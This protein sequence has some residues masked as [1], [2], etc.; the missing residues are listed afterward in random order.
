MTIPEDHKEANPINERTVDGTTYRYEYS[1]K[2]VDVGAIDEDM[3]PNNVDMEHQGDCVRWQYG[4]RCPVFIYE[5]KVT[6]PSEYQEKVADN[7]AY[8]ALSILADE[9]MVS[10]FSKVM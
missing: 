3:A 10:G 9:G 6:Y 8:F 5:D 1:F 4:D 2:G 7:Q